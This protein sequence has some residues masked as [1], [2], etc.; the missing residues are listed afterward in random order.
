MRAR[1]LIPIAI[2]GLLLLLL[3][4]GLKLWPVEEVAKSW[5]GWR[6]QA[7]S[8]VEDPPGQ[9]RA[10]TEVELTRDGERVRFAKGTRIVWHDGKPVE[11]APDP[12]SADVLF[13]P[14]F[15]PARRDL[16]SS[17]EVVAPGA[18]E[19]EE[20]DPLL[21]TGQVIDARSGL[22]LPN[23]EVHF[24]FSHS[25]DGY[26]PL[27]VDGARGVV[28]VASDGTFRVPVFEPDDPQL[29]LH[30]EVHSAEHMPL[31]HVIERGH[32]TVGNWPYV[33]LPLRLATTSTLYFRKLDA[34]LPGGVAIEVED[35]TQDRYLGEDTWDEGRTWRAGRPI[36]RYTDED[37]SLRVA[38]GEHRYRVM[39]PEYWMWDSERREPFLYYQ[40]SPHQERRLGRSA[41]EWN[42]IDLGSTEQ[43]VSTLVDARGLPIANTLV[44]AEL[45][46]VARGPVTR[47][48]RFYTGAHG[49]FQLAPHP[50]PERVVDAEEFENP[51]SGDVAL[52]A[53]LLCTE[54]PRLTRLTL[55]SPYFWKKRVVYF[56]TTKGQEVAVNALPAA[57]LKMRLVTMEE[58]DDGARVEVPAPANDFTI[59]GPEWTV[60]RRGQD[61]EVLIVGTIPKGLAVIEFSVRG[62]EP[63]TAILPAHVASVGHL[64]LGKVT[65]KQG[66]SLQ[67]TVTAA[68]AA[69][70]ERAVVRFAPVRQPHF[71]HQYPIGSDGRVVLSGLRRGEHYRLAV[72]GSRLDPRVTRWFVDAGSV[73]RGVELSAVPKNLQ[74]VRLSG[75][76]LHIPADET[77]QYRVVER[78]HFDG[79]WA[80]LTTAT[81]PLPP[82]GVFGSVRWLPLSDSAEVFVV[83]PALRAWHH[84]VVHEPHAARF[85]L[86]RVDPSESHY[87]TLRFCGYSATAAYPTIELYSGRR[88]DHEVARVEPIALNAF[89]DYLFIDN[90]QPGRHRIQWQQDKKLRDFF[91]EI[92]EG[93]PGASFV[94]PC[95][96][97]ELVERVVR[98]VDA[99][100]KGVDGVDFSGISAV[101][102]DVEDVVVP[103]GLGLES[104]PDPIT[105]PGNYLTRFLGDRELDVGLARSGFLPQQLRVP[106]GRN[107]PETFHLDAGVLLSG[108]VEDAN[109]LPFDGVIDVAWSRF[110]SVDDGD[111]I[112]YFGAVPEIPIKRGA[113]E[114]FVAPSG[115]YRFTFSDLDS[116]ARDE[117]WLDLTPEK[118]TV[119][120][121]LRETRSLRGTVWLPDGEPAVDAIV[122]LVDPEKAEHWPQRDPVPLDGMSFSTRTDAAGRFEISGLPVDLSRE[123]ALVAHLDGFLDA[124][125]YDV[126]LQRL[127]QPLFLGLGTRLVLD[128]GYAE[129]GDFSPYVFQLEHA[130]G[131]SEGRDLGT[132][133]PTPVGGTGYRGVT[134]GYYLVRWAHPEYPE[135]DY[136]YQQAWAEAHVLSGGDETLL[137]RPAERVAQARVRLNGQSLA[138]GWLI[139][140]SDPSDPSATRVLR[141]LGG[142]ASGLLPVNPSA[143]FALFSDSGPPPDPTRGEA[144]LRPIPE[145][146]RQSTDSYLLEY[147]GNDLAIQFPVDALETHESISIQFPHYE[148][149]G[150]DYRKTLVTEKVAANPFRLRLLPPGVFTFTVWTGPSHRISYTVD[151]ALDPVFP[152]G[153]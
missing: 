50:Y 39:D 121:R 13:G 16:T 150:G 99:K 143:H 83:G 36:I 152:V 51:C 133:L 125:L 87:A 23:A 19:A 97:D 70:L 128:I 82:D 32:D 117:R 59:V 102:L 100:G 34:E 134:P 89:Q 142:R 67:V 42:T 84:E 91:F 123:Q 105:G 25:D 132:L 65:L 114:E 10:T 68:T 147:Q 85:D 35:L 77:A 45:S 26:P 108:R 88:R 64:D 149:R 81:Y 110:V 54:S 141:V 131:N 29:Y 22:P 2:I 116:E 21:P 127:E 5:Q 101:P 92:V 6:I 111:P 129:A 106:Q 146:A 72:D 33:T 3:W 73:L 38:D 4:A 136:G 52:P 47:R 56:A 48:V 55:L 46:S 11:V 75:V 109:R 43:G 151:P 15:S 76:A 60:V 103:W 139:A 17:S 41:Q 144:L 80:P 1:V 28:L 112:E 66:E 58:G 9:F 78:Y 138:T 153:L 71:T 14:A 119:R 98:V 135:R 7:G 30:L 130:F 57:Q 53:D 44:E 113:M 79:Q 37:G 94:V 145:D 40:V 126:D 31:V 18:S 90:L 95:V 122:A 27:P 61:G 118:E 104:L 120:L 20:P 115:Q 86:G 74:E 62:F 69:L 148:W 124:V 24:V 12:A 49:E 137:L 93:E 96:D 63:A 8:W 140:T 107:L